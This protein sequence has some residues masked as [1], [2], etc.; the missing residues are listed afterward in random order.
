MIINDTAILLRVSNKQSLLRGGH[1]WGCK[2]GDVGGEGREEPAVRTPPGA[3]APRR[4]RTLSVESR[5]PWL[6]PGSRPIFSQLPPL[7]AVLP[8]PTPS[9]IPP[10]MGSFSLHW[11]FPLPR[12]F[13]QLCPGLLMLTVQISAQTQRGLPEIYLLE[14]FLSSRPPLHTIF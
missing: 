8:P 1:S 12:S 2:G 7:R 14:N 11:R 13:L 5:G 3:W 9:L 4:T 10:P 6:C